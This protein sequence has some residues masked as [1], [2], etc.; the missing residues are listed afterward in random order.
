MHLSLTLRPTPWP[1]LTLRPMAILISVRW[2]LRYPTCCPLV[3]FSHKGASKMLRV[4]GHARMVSSFAVARGARGG[5]ALRH[6]ARQCL[7]TNTPSAGG[8][9][10]VQPKKT[11]K[12]Q[13]KTSPKFEICGSVR[14]FW[15]ATP[16][17]RRCLMS[18]PLPRSGGPGRARGSCRPIYFQFENLKTSKILKTSKASRRPGYQTQT[19]CEQ[20]LVSRCD[21]NMFHIIIR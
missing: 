21:Q 8:G 6:R 9:G 12:N 13:K 14:F 3:R 7:A 17:A 18:G 15:V 20:L 16:L 11:K 19:T 2:Q 5:A 10:G 1:C 4:T